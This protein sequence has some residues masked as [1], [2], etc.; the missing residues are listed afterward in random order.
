MGIDINIPAFPGGTSGKEPTCQCR[1][2]KRCGFNPRL[3]KIP[4]S[5]AW[6]PNPI[7]LPRESRG[8]KCLAGYSPWGHKES[9]MTKVT[10]HS[11]ARCGC[12][13]HSLTL[14]LS[15]LKKLLSSLPSDLKEL[16]HF[17]IFGCLSSLRCRAGFSLAVA[18]RSHS[19]VPV[20]RFSIAAASLVA[21][22]GLYDSQTLVVTACGLSSCS[23][24]APEHRLSS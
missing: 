16:F 5:R 20:H 6:Q 15:F 22:C 10:E 2:H 12:F 23:F 14:P 13:Y 18:S 1:R 19:L 9:D 11:T 7:F 17:F 3:G 4:W 24:Q 8:Q 21:G